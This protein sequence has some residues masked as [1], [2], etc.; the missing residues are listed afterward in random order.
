MKN[1]PGREQLNER[2]T[3]MKFPSELRSADKFLVD[4]ES[5]AKYLLRFVPAISK[6][7]HE[8]HSEMQMTYTLR[9][10][11]LCPVIEELKHGIRKPLNSIQPLITPYLTARV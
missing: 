2:L 4:H 9:C 11:H 7:T 5:G 8:T 3:R 6:L 10:A 1:Q